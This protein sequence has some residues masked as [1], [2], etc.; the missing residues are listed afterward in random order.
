MECKFGDKHV[1][2][3][4][5]TDGAVFCESPYR[6]NSG[7]VTFRM[8]TGAARLEAVTVLQF[9]YLSASRVQ[10]LSPERGALTGGT[11]VS[12]RGTGFVGDRVQ[13]RFGAQRVV[14]KGVNVVSSTLVQCS[15]PA[16]DNLG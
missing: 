16:S 2:A 15:A 1:V 13:C 5:G 12:V 3:E 14:E 11:L 7:A 6:G 4:R 10:R 8:V 9:V